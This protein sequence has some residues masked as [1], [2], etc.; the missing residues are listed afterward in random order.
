MSLIYGAPDPINLY[1]YV[2]NKYRPNYSQRF[3]LLKT[4]CDGGMAVRNLNVVY[5]AVVISRFL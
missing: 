3:Y 1:F 2:V 4:L 5:C